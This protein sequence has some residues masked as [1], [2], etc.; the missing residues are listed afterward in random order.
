MT[1]KP[2]SKMQKKC[3]LCCVVEWLAWTPNTAAGAG[4]DR[5]CPH[6]PRVPAEPRAPRLLV[7]L[8]LLWLPAAASEADVP[9][10]NWAGFSPTKVCLPKFCSAPCCRLG[11]I[12]QTLVALK[13][14]HR[15]RFETCGGHLSGSAT[16]PL[17]WNFADGC[18]MQAPISLLVS[19]YP[20]A[21]QLRYM[22]ILLLLFVIGCPSFLCLTLKITVL[23]IF[24]LSKCVYPA[25]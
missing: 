24:A 13:L 21:W 19:T 9:K 14:E 25:W 23:A 15:F 10:V 20:C 22:H 8:R 18:S 2:F 5:P 16:C 6:R 11:G 3:N 17:L 12:N 7:E 4:S 1:S